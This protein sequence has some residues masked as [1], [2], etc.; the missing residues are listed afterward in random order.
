[1]RSALPILLA[2][3][4]T[5][6]A[7]GARAQTGPGLGAVDFSGQLFEPVGFIESPEGHGNVTMVQGY[8]MVIYST[9]GG[10]D[11]TNGGIEFWDVSDPTQPTLVVRHDDANT[12]G[13]REAHG[14]SLSWDGARLVLAAQGVDGVQ[15]WD[16]TDPMSI[17]LLSYLDLPGIDKG[18]YSGDW[19]L[20]WQAP[21]LYVAG[22]DSGLYI[23]DASDPEDPLLVRQMPT[24]ELAGV[25]PAQVF[26]LGNLLVVME[27]QGTAFA[28]LDASDPH[29]PRVLRRVSGKSG[30]SHLF[31]GDGK[32]L[33]S[34]NIPPR[35]HVHQ[36][37]ANGSIT[38]ESSFGLFFD[39][40]GYGSYQ[41]G[42]FHSGFSDNYVKFDVAGESVEGSGTG[43]RPD[44]DED[45]AT[46][47]GN[48]VVAGND[49]GSGTALIPHQAAPDT[50]PPAV[51]W[52]HPP[53]DAVDVALTTR[54]GLSF[55]DHV[56]AASLNDTTVWL[57]KDLTQ[58]KVAAR[59]SAQL[60]LVNV[61]PDAP[62]ERNTAYKV[63][64]DG[65]LDVAGNAS[66]RFE[67]TIT[68]GEGGAILAPGDV[69]LNISNSSVL[70]NVYAVLSFGAGA[71]VYGDRDYT[72]TADHPVRFGGQPYIQTSNNDK[73]SVSSGFLTFDLA[74]PAEVAVLYDDRASSLPDWL[75]AFTATAE[76]VETTDADFTVHAADYPAGSVTLGGNNA[77]GAAGQDSMYSVVVRPEQLECSLALSPALAGT[78]SLDVTG[79]ADASYDWQV[80]ETSLTDAGRAVQLDLPPGR[81]GVVVT[82][83]KA[84]RVATCSGVLVVHRPLVAEPALTSSR[85]AFSGARTINVNP[86]NGTVTAVDADARTVAW[87]VAVGTRPA[88]VAISG[89]SAWVTLRDDDKL[90]ELSAS[91]GTVLTTHALP[92]A[93]R[94]HGVV[95][96][97]DGKLYVTLSATGE[98]ARVDPAT[99]L[100]ARAVVG[101]T[102]RGLTFFDG[103]LYVSRFLSPDTH[104][105]LW[106][107]NP[108][109]L[110]VTDTVALAYDEGPDTEATGRGVPNYLSPLYISPDGTLGFVV[111][112]KDNVGRGLYR[113]G[114]ELTFESRVR[115]FVAFVDLATGQE[116]VE[117]R[118]DPND[119]E[120][121]RSAAVSPLGDL[122][123][124]ASQGVNIV[125]VFEVATGR[126]VSQF[127]VGL[128]PQAV[129]FDGAG[130]RLAVYNFL[131]RSLTFLDPSDILSGVGNNVEELGV[132]TVVADEALDATVLAGKRV[133][134][135][136]SDERM[137]R[138][139]Y[140][141]CA[142]CH[143]DG[144]H[145][146]RTWDFTQAGEG[147]RNTITLRGRA[148][149]AHGN[150]H[151][152]A[153]FDEIQDF[154]NDIRGAF[155]GT[156]FL[157]EEDWTATSDPLG[158]PKA[159]RSPELD[160]LAA[161]VATFTS[162]PA[163]PHR[164]ED[165]GF[166]EAARRGRVVFV[167]AD[168]HSCHGSDAFSDFTRHDVGTA[169]PG[170]GQGIGAPLVGVGFE[171]PTLRGVWS[172]PPY[173][174]DGSAA[175]LDD[176][177]L[178]HGEIPALEPDAR[179]DLVAYLEQLDDDASA[180][181]TDCALANECVGGAASDGGP[182]GPGVDAG[183]VGP[184]AD[185]GTVDESPE[186]CACGATSAV[187]PDALFFGLLFVVALRRRR[188]RR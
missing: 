105:E 71:T 12:H 39:S 133:F 182:A 54:V 100:E 15:L 142:S 132:T 173:L 65:V 110:E 138:D 13:L 68:T 140:I 6:V 119:R 147:L 37:G 46:V 188:R 107:V 134:H 21:T 5:L 88:S 58:E 44:H 156:G 7:S 69:V 28:T 36:V 72:F 87:E 47:L 163:S 166:T 159:G 112:K 126:R 120:L 114:L 172:T 74:V 20:F 91:S 17:S 179:A 43:G 86:D 63:V 148:G 186:D 11:A 73:L 102:A 153:N 16:V 85:L 118:I 45:F 178:A 92:R 109:T 3:A 123:F 116:L 128:G 66:A 106:I 125:D 101:P 62:L 97:P 23:V 76:T 158:T 143:L 67:A 1:M 52:L 150:V 81:H 104:G 83:T 84:P 27:S 161:Y 183:P 146:G 51:V 162:V 35:A 181:E 160:A 164:A 175:T 26:A 111:G 79:P 50:T 55:S 75:S 89:G 24:G 135:D 129:A 121:V 18:D 180:P 41:D 34:G 141:S 30:Y 108:A 90:L 53:A 176:A 31:A 82:A 167:E 25:S 38:F 137:T 96:A 14:F 2:A 144:G 42:Y 131:S 77:S 98:V 78:V 184:G 60:G 149:V 174:H 122:L 94:P 22:V 165:G 113:D 117:R 4:A 19:W 57:E 103:K 169:G 170:S 124:I 40:G 187:A 8:L 139:G 33:T 171:T 32:I 151:W 64:A 115:T 56:D 59:L 80:G 93:S 168:C 99:G 29:A 70:N 152:T 145:D 185:A 136:A 10:G 95:V 9:D 48:L 61:A 177:L 127:D 155:G 154:E 157:S 49:H 130:A